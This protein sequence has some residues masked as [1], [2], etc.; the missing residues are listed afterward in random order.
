MARHLCVFWVL[1]A[2]VGNLCFFL[3]FSYF[4]LRV[5]L[6]ALCMHMYILRRDG[7]CL[8]VFLCR[9]FSFNSLGFM[10]LQCV[11]LPL[12]TSRKSSLAAADTI[13]GRKLFL[14]TV[15]AHWR[16]WRIFTINPRSFFKRNCW[17]CPEFA[18]VA[19]RMWVVIVHC[20][21][22]RVCHDLRNC[23]LQRLSLQVYFAEE[24]IAL[25]KSYHKMCFACGNDL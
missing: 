5:F 4:Y 22:P 12:W 10:Y 7:C 9:L 3:L 16:I 24:K 18:L 20:F 19:K 21:V 2:D 1:G 6:C 14:T 17:K 23:H 11:L 8:D 15:P 13:R 25:G